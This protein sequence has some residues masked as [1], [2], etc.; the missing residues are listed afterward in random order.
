MPNDNINKD[1]VE[2]LKR[3]YYG[4]STEDDIKIYDVYNEP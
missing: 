2:R 3:R 1:V 4:D